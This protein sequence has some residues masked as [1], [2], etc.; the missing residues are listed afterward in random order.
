[1][2]VFVKISELKISFE[3]EK[4]YLVREHQH[5]KDILNREH[6]REKVHLRC[7]LLFKVR[8]I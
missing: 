8:F 7:R 2:F 5:E 1:M 6:E 3:Q 4:T